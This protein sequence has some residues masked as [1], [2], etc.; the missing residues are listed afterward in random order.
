MP[1]DDRRS[2]LNFLL[3]DYHSN[4]ILDIVRWTWTK[5]E[6]NFNSKRDTVLFKLVEN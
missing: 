6:L 3:S 4:Y 5:Y 1:W 2:Y